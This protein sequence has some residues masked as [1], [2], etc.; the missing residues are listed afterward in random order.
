M[1]RSVATLLG[2]EMARPA[3]I[4]V[5]RHGPDGRVVESPLDGLTLHRVIRGQRLRKVGGAPGSFYPGAVRR[6]FDKIAR[7]N[8][9]EPILKRFDREVLAVLRAKGIRPRR[10]RAQPWLALRVADRPHTQEWFAAKILDEL[11]MLRNAM[12]KGEAHI[13]VRHTIILME[14]RRIALFKSLYER[15]T[16]TRLRTSRGP[17]EQRQKQAADKSDL[18]ERIRTAA[19]DLR[20]NRQHYG[21]RGI[22][23]TLA[24]QFKRSPRTVQRAL[25]EDV[26]RVNARGG[27]S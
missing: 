9:P 5:T 19:S 23:E 7:N 13:A 21:L 22:K 11:Y 18:Y 14:L 2:G 4:V 25:N 15:P 6:L 26:S 3:K 12:A 1:P 20:R 17:A 8:D 16:I 24:A 10:S 27:V